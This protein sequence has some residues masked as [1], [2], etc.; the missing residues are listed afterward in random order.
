MHGL[1]VIWGTGELGRENSYRPRAAMS[2]ELKHSVRRRSPHASILYAILRYGI[3][4]AADQTSPA[5]SSSDI[6]TAPTCPTI[7]APF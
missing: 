7:P 1:V 5:T 2:W 3:C 6:L 4:T